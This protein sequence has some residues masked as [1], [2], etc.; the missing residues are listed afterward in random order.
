MASISAR[1]TETKV[2]GGAL[3]V[4]KKK[5]RGGN[6][7][8][9]P[10]RIVFFFFFIA[11]Y[12]RKSSEVSSKNDRGDQGVCSVKNQFKNVKIVSVYTNTSCVQILINR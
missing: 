4:F 5:A 3:T 12:I 10:E 7:C 9:P 2:F 1:N 11:G 6:R 8:K